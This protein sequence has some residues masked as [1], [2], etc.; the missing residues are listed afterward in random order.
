MRAKDKKHAEEQAQA[1]ADRFG[2]PYVVF[3][4]TNGNY[5]VERSESAWYA[6]QLNGTTFNPKANEV[7]P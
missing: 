6:S 7:Q 4:D 2:V 5:R 3:I 1:N